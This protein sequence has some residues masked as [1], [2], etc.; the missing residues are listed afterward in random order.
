MR[1]SQFAFNA[2]NTMR[3]TRTRWIDLF[4]D[5]GARIELVYIE[6]PLSLILERN[7]R[8]PQPVPA[9][10]D[11]AAGGQAEAADLDRGS[12]A[13]HDRRPRTRLM[14]TWRWY[15]LRVHFAA[16]PSELLVPMCSSNQSRLRF[17]AS[18]SSFGSW[19]AWWARG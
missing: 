14:K 10:G 6:P 4:A 18:S 13:D 19:I 8:R 9:A 7:L 1:S 17:M 11:R 16:V 2:T 12:F 5:Y 15:T 3:Q